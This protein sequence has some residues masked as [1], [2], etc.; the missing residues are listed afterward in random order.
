MQKFLLFAA[1]LISGMSAYGQAQVSLADRMQIAG[2]TKQARTLAA[3]GE[4]V[5]P[6]VML[7]RVEN[8]DAIADLEKSG[9]QV[10][11]TEGNIVIAEVP[12]D[13][14][15]NV[16]AV[17]GISTASLQQKAR[18]VNDLARQST[19]VDR[20]TAGEGL[21]Q[22][23]DGTGVI[24]GIYDMGVDPNHV[25]FNDDEG[26]SRIS[27]F[28]HFASNNGS[29]TEYTPDN[30][31]TFKTDNTEETH[32]T[33]TMGTLA[34]AFHGLPDGKDYSGVATGAEIVAGAGQGYNENMLA[35]VRKIAD[36]AD[37]VGKPAVI[38]LSWGANDVSAHDGSDEFTTAL[39][40][41]ASRD[42][43]HLFLASGNEGDDPVGVYKQFTADDK[44]LR[45]F[46]VPTRYATYYLGPETQAFGNVV[47]WSDS[48]EPF[49]TTLEVININDP[50]NP[51]YIHEVTSDTKFVVSG[52]NTPAGISASQ[53]DYNAE[54]FNNIYSDSYMGG[55]NTLY[56]GNR[57]FCC[58]LA[59]ALESANSTYA[60]NYFVAIHVKGNPGQKV[61]AYASFNS[62]YAEPLLGFGN[63]GVEGFDASN[64]DGTLSNLACGKNMIVVGA[65]AT[66]Q[67]EDYLKGTTELLYP[68]ETLGDVVTF[69][70]WGHML[71]GTLR[72][73]VLAPGFMTMS[74]MSTPYAEANLSN[75]GSAKFPTLIKETYTKDGKSYY[76]TVLCGTSMAT[77]HM[78]GIAALWLQADPT[79]TTDDIRNI[80]KTTSTKPAEA[81]DA[82]GPNGRVDAY[83]GL[84]QI[85]RLDGLANVSSGENSILFQTLGNGVYEIAAPGETE[86]SV[87]V[88]DLRGITVYTA[89]ANGESLQ[90]DTS[91]MEPGF[92]VMTAASPR[93]TASQKI[94]VR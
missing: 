49:V 65:Y 3:K 94:A 26:R 81:S 29:A 6:T 11:Q 75:L 88:T 51:V 40:N 32:G 82:W 70:S 35:A 48:A 24:T 58:E 64:G 90:V 46:I 86:L 28:W 23:Y 85:L 25:A 91:D 56:R 54:E 13:R 21:P 22:A 27:H 5:R 33:H 30:I 52:Y 39:D 59:F 76:W 15:E 2:L 18:P 92:Y 10:V 36:Y 8:P 12:V 68:H 84:K 73:D 41:I 17:K 9:A 20:I 66:R 77:P 87:T 53:I 37:S 34:S 67:S 55:V 79:L 80:I 74:T 7:F 78:A 93:G 57:C 60:Q 62:T 45:T 1:A 47:I 16:L 38:S 63:K 61:H 44:E 71:D 72:P 42:N 19:G 43:V 4:T 83:E 69:S 31:A 50:E 89:S 14:I